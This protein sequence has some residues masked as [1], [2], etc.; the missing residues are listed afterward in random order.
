M[1][2][3]EEVET[4]HV[5]QVIC[6]QQEIDGGLG[7]EAEG[8]FSVAH[9]GESDFTAEVKLQLLAVRRVSVDNEDCHLFELHVIH[10]VGPSQNSQLMKSSFM[11][12]QFVQLC[13]V[14][15]LR[16]LGNH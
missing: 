14:C 3:A 12:K 7:E 16:S 6:N 2:G 11:G 15:G 10:V 5:R 4:C 1:D 8:I 9:T 13:C